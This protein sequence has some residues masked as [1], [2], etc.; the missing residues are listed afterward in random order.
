MFS[1]VLFAVFVVSVTAWE[2]VPE[3]YELTFSPEDRELNEDFY[4]YMHQPEH[5]RQTR[6]LHGSTMVN[7][8]GST[9][10]TFIDIWLFVQCLSISR[11]L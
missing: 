7:S 2:I 1:P 10:K 9:G 6:Q 3:G 11:Y 5:R 8:D 4:Q